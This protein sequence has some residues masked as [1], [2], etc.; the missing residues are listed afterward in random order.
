MTRLN[1][2]LNE[3][4]DDQELTDTDLDVVVGG[5]ASDFGDREPFANAGPRQ[6]LGTRSRESPIHSSSD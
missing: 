6:V 4:A 5:L 3:P 1:L 2:S